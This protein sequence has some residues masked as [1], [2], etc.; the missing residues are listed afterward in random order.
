VKG[1]VRSTAAQHLTLDES[2]VV[3]IDRNRG[4]LKTHNEDG[5][6]EGASSLDRSSD[7]NE[8]TD[9]INDNL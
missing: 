7:G 1:S 2:L 3:N 9:I 4:I 6:P 8:A 5:G